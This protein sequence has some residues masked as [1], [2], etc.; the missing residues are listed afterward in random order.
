[1][2]PWASLSPSLGSPVGRRAGRGRACSVAGSAQ[3][4]L[5]APQLLCIDAS[6]RRRS[7]L[8]AGRSALPAK[9]GRDHGAGAE[10]PATP[11]CA[12]PF[13]R[14]STVRPQAPLEPRCAPPY[15]GGRGPAALRGFPR[16]PRL[17]PGQREHLRLALCPTGAWPGELFR[18]SAAQRAERRGCPKLGGV[19]SRGGGGGGSGSGA[20]PGAAGSSP[21]PGVAPQLGEGG[22]ARAAWTQPLPGKESA[23][24]LPRISPEARPRRARRCEGGGRRLLPQEGHVR[25]GGRGTP[26]ASVLPSHR[27]RRSARTA[28]KEAAALPDARSALAAARPGGDDTAPAAVPRRRVGRLLT[29]SRLPASVSAAPPPAWAVPRA[30]TFPRAWRPR[31][32]LAPRHRRCRPAGRASRRARRRPPCPGPAAPASWSWSLAT[33]A[34]R[35]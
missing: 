10:P 15:P 7:P 28:I 21:P 19:W 34:A 16:T 31:T 25:R 8:G 18:E 33:A 26:P 22:V 1:M 3:R 13:L 6:T 30:S 23:N 4:R 20:G 32:H 27:R 14:F 12:Q 17:N 29:G 5:L 2:C 35:R 11:G 9:P 24:L